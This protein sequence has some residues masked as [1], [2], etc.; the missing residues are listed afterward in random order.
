MIRNVVPEAYVHFLSNQCQTRTLEQTEYTPEN[1]DPDVKPYPCET[2]EDLMEIVSQRLHITPAWRMTFATAIAVQISIRLGGNNL[3]MYVVGPAASGKTTLVELI[4]ANTT[5]SRM[6][7]K[8]TGLHSG[9]NQGGSKSGK[10]ASLFA[11][12]DK[13]VVIV[14]DFTTVLGLEAT[15]RTRIFDELRDAYDGHTSNVYRNHIRYEYKDVRFGFIAAVTDRIRQFGTVNLG[16]RFLQMQIDGYWDE[17]YVLKKVTTDDDTLHMAVTGSLRTLLSPVA[18]VNHRFVEQR[19]AAWGFSE[20]LIQTIEQQPDFVHSILVNVEKNY[21]NYICALSRIVAAFRSR[22]DPGSLSPMPESPTR[23][24]TVLPKAMVCLCL[25]HGITE[26]SL[27]VLETVFKNSF[28]SGISHNQDVILAL[29][30]RRNVVCSLQQI[31]ADTGHDPTT[32]KRV[33]AELKALKFVFDCGSV[34]ASGRGR[35]SNGYAL[36]PDLRGA[37]DT[38]DHYLGKDNSG[39]KPRESQRSLD[40]YEY[41]LSTNAVD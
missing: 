8:F 35:P 17:G 32:V 38:V 16:E 6:I 3:W 24:A 33:I 2:F 10:D 14:K 25:V 5:T 40:D 29:A 22:V 11:M 30:R 21:L 7:S 9:F 23:L 12:I 13:K 1:F 15:A 27:E 4:A 31:I 26:P 18:S 37:F 41:D 20:F 28:D 39:P 36:S 34:A 19:S